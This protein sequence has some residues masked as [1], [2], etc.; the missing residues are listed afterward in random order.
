MLGYKRLI[1]V[2]A[3]LVIQITPQERMAL[4]KKRIDLIESLPAIAGLQR[5]LKIAKLKYK[6]AYELSQRQL[7]SL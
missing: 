1:S 7:S 6:S 4:W 5:D 2:M 3:K